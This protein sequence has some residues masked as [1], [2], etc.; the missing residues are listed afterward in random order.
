[1][2]RRKCRSRKAHYRGSNLALDALE[3]IQDAQLLPPTP[4]RPARLYT[5]TAVI[6]CHCGGYVLTSSQGKARGGRPLPRIT[7]RR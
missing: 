4:D 7:R 2:K 3:L 6:R 1:M 5:P